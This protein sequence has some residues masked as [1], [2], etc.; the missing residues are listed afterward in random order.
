M[1]RSNCAPSGGAGGTA[2]VRLAREPQSWNTDF[3]FL[4]FL[5]LFSRIGIRDDDGGGWW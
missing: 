2:A 5:F 4:F 3:F 1:C